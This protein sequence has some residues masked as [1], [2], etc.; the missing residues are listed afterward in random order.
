MGRLGVRGEASEEI[1]GMRGMRNGICSIGS[2]DLQVGV[3][4]NYRLC[5]ECSYCDFGLFLDRLPW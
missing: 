3:V 2:M 1:T 5:C 4:A